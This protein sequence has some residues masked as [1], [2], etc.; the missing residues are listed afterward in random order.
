MAFFLTGRDG[1]CFGFLQAGEKGGVF[2][3]T[4]FMGMGIALGMPCFKK[5]LCYAE[6][7]S[8]V[9]GQL[10]SF[11]RRRTRARY[12]LEYLVWAISSDPGSLEY[13][14]P[15]SVLAWWAMIP[16]LVTLD[17]LT[18][19]SPAR[20]ARVL[21]RLT[22]APLVRRHNLRVRT[23]VAELLWR[24]PFISGQGLQS[25]DRCGY[26]LLAGGLFTLVKTIPRS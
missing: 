9:T 24:T 8:Y 11:G 20:Q 1:L 26:I 4:A 25:A 2:A 15:A 3:R 16:L 17:R 13:W 22:A 21:K 23:F 19:C 18:R 6:T 14:W 5:S 12:Y 7:P 10:T